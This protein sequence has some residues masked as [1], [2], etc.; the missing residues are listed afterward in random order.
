MK[1]NLIFL[2]L[3]LFLASLL[4][5]CALKEPVSVPRPSNEYSIIDGDTIKTLI[6]KDYLKAK[7]F[8]LHSASYLIL[9]DTSVTYQEPRLHTPPATA[10]DLSNLKNND[11]PD[12]KYKPL[13]YIAIGGSLAAGVRDGGYF[14]EGIMTSYP[15]LIARQM[16]LAK[17]EQPLFDKQNYNGYGRLAST[18]SNPTGG[19]VP[20]FN[21]V[22]N[23]S[24]ITYVDQKTITLKT[25]KEKAGLDNFAIPN[26]SLGGLYRYNGSMDYER[27]G[28][29]LVNNSFF[30]RIIPK[31]PSNPSLFNKVFSQK[32][33]FISFEFGYTEVLNS[34]LPGYKREFYSNQIPDR[35][36][37][38]SDEPSS[39]LNMGLSAEL[40]FVRELRENKGTKAVLLNIPDFLSLPYFKFAH[41]E[42]L[43]R[44]FNNPTIIY[45]SYFNDG[46]RLIDIQRDSLL[47]T[48]AIDSLLSYKVHITLKKGIYHTIPLSFWDILHDANRFAEVTRR[49]NGEISSISEKFGF[50][51]VDIKGL[52]EKI[53][54]G[55][56]VTDDGVMVDAGYPNGNFFSS[57]G[58]FP[59]PFGQ[60]IIANEVI[61]TINRHYKT[62]IPLI[63]AREYLNR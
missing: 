27:F 54:K 28:V 8:D 61:K 41:N 16:K 44:V 15:N 30:Y 2:S 36:V 17:F 12:L 62:N 55:Q 57:D 10:P 11:D 25:Y 49:Y 40:I 23:N 63:S 22:T 48:P 6:N 3:I 31:D 26:F 35:D 51:I 4:S 5:S 37:I 24:A 39:E 52:Y 34:F 60:A 7:R 42:L 33:D 13:R 19:P 38:F 1:N 14:N 20:K 56:F 21:A 29:G 9:G 32:F 45:Q 47:P 43:K 58:L 18:S 59:T 53:V 46:V 50:P